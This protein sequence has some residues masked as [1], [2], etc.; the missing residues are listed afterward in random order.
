MDV[1][2]AWD[3]DCQDLADIFLEPVYFQ[4]GSTVIIR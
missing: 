2:N 1:D 4:N 3:N